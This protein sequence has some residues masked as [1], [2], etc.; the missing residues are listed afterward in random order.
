MSPRLLDRFGE[1]RAPPGAYD[2]MR[3]SR[4]CAAQQRGGNPQSSPPEV[5][6]LA[7]IRPL[8]VLL[9][10]LL[11]P[12]LAPR[13]AAAQWQTNGVLVC[14]AANDQTLPVAV[15]DGAG[16]V[17][18]A[19]NDSRNGAD[20][21]VYAQHLLASGAADAGWPS[22]G[23]GVCV[24]VGNQSDVTIVGDGSGGAIIT[25]DDRRNGTDY[26][27]FAQ[28]VLAS[29]AV[30][31][32]WPANGRAL[33]TATNQQL[34][35]TIASDQAGGAIVAWHDNRSGTDYDIY[36]QHVQASGAVDPAWPANGRAL[37]MAGG[38]QVLPAITRDAGSG[39]V[40]AWDDHRNG[41]DFDIYAQH[42]MASGAVDPGWPA[43]GRGICTSTND[44]V[45]VAIVA[46][47]GGG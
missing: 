43:D 39:A 8:P 1:H 32:A 9:L 25:W 2:C 35:P 36:A 29:G 24:T 19:W 34:F 20:S 3:C 28:H 14:A 40:V 15:P 27:I 11:S 12:M 23:R 37:C 30:D 6:M 41:T 46:D 22:N 31:P 26:N 4:I 42:V 44:Q 38:D 16:G 10:V 18:I 13:P 33:C 45:L 21:D 7:R 5:V 17:I 47:G